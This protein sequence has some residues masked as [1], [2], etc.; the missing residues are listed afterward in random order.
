MNHFIAFLL[1]LICCAPLGAQGIPSGRVLTVNELSHYITD[2]AKE[3][4]EHNDEVT[5][6]QLAL[7]FLLKRMMLLLMKQ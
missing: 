7:Y 1:G 4:M 5:V 6:A 2:D 3:A